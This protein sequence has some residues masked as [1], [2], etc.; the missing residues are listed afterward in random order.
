M[1]MEA[2]LACEPMIG[3]TTRGNFNEPL[4]TVRQV[5]G[6][7]STT[8]RGV[9]IFCSVSSRRRKYLLQAR[10]AA[11]TLLQGMLVPL[12]KCDFFPFDISTT[13]SGRKL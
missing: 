7:L 1:F 11:T 13:F 10:L 4:S 8:V 9:G 5:A 12:K 2:P 3:L 6:C